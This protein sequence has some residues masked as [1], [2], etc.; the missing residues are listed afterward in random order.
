M[1]TVF[2]GLTAAEVAERRRA[3]LD[4]RPVEAPSKSLG[5]IIRSNLLTYFNLVFLM[6]AIILILVKSYLD[7]TFL[8]VILANIVIGIV[9]EWRSKQVLDKLTVLHT[10][11]AR[12]LREGK[13][14]SVPVKD[15]VLDDVVKFKAGDQIPADAVVLLG[16]MTVNESLLTGEADEI[17]KKEGASLLS[18]SFVVSGE[19]L[20]RLTQVGADAYAAKLTLQAKAIKVGEQSEI[21]RSL[22][23]FVQ[24][25]G[26]AIIPIGI[27][28][29]SQ[30]Y[31][32]GEADAK[33]AVQAMV[34]AIIG[35]IPEGLFL[36]SSVTLAISA[37]RLALNKVLIHDMKCIETLARVDVLCVDKTGTITSDKVV[38]QE[39]IEIG[40]EAGQKLEQ[41]VRV[42]R[43]DNATMQ[44]LKAY[45]PKKTGEEAKRVWGFSSKY[46]YS[47]AEFQEGV[48]VLGAP[49]FVLKEQYQKH[50]KRIEKYSKKGYRVLVFGRCGEGAIGEELSMEVKLEALIVMANEVRKT[51]SET[52]R[53]FREQDVEV[54][55]ISG[56][57]PDTVAEVARQAGILGE[58][59]D[60]RELLTEKSLKIAAVEGTIFGRVTPDQKRKLVQALQAAGKT[61]AMTGD[62]VNDVLALKDADCSVAMASG[63]DAAVQAAQLVLLESDFSKMPAI[64]REGRRVVNNLERSGSL[65]LVK[66]VFSL[67]MAVLAICF[68]VTYPLLPTQISMVTLFTIGV[69]SFLLAQIPNE[70]LIK[71]QFL[72]N[73]LKQAIPAGLANVILVGMI[74]LF[75]QVLNLEMKFTSTVATLVMVLVGLIFLFK[76]CK[77]FNKLKLAIWSL[78]VIGSIISATVLGGLYGINHQLPMAAISMGLVAG[79]SALPM[80]TIMEKVVR[81][82]E[83]QLEKYYGR[84]A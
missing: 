54:K 44:A 36:L 76:L 49:E 82:M 64:V 28:L 16:D 11:K 17:M 56:D 5:E 33:T 77:P 15:L 60:A 58:V 14:L 13:I 80:L 69:P 70:K 83:Q 4:N 61:V 6:I 27:I 46:K 1:K 68:S 30:Q 62:G 21:I 74:M 34:A 43:A 40:Q 23:K 45:F 29:F 73:I 8:P 72:W 12:V 24:L 18:G 3:G 67:V 65:F 48:F 32:F 42:Q 37:M 78:C 10:P 55:V 2:F 63:S 41:F 71:G 75:G 52:F 59:I 31:L 7:L 9:Q 26:I 79:I 39:V 22:N 57:N 53:Y 19:C 35:M 84:I 47:A 66:N 25:A 51:A 50:A 20:A 38:V 81:M